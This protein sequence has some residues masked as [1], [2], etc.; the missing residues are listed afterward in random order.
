MYIKRKKI[1]SFIVKGVV[2]IEEF[3][4]KIHQNP[5]LSG[6]EYE[7]NLFVTK[8]LLKYDVQ[9]YNN[10]LSIVC[11]FN[12][13]KKQTVAFRSELDALPIKENVNHL[14]KSLN[15]N[16]HAC[17]HDVH[18]SALLSL[19]KYVS[20]NDFE[21]NIAFIFQSKEEGGLGAKE[22]IETSIFDELNITK[23]IGMHVWPNLEFDQL[24]SSENLMFGS[25]ELDVLIKGEN[26]H[27]SC[28]NKMTDATYASYKLY[29]KLYKNNKK[30]IYHLGDIKSG[31]L[32]NISSDKA[33]M[34][35]SLR[36]YNDCG[37]KET[38]LKKK[39]NTKCNI[40]YDFKGYFP[41]LKNDLSLLKLI[42]Y[43]EIKTLKSA[44]D[45]G[46]YRE[47]CE[48]LY[49]LYGLGKGFSL[50][51]SDFNTTEDIRVKYREKLLML[52][53]IFK[54]KAN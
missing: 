46:Y 6:L 14:I 1:I 40:T 17:G 31:N 12:K 50:H 13:N 52:I 47:K 48:T 19:A 42:D 18:T 24:F 21:Y 22:L 49:L 4:K 9:I 39:I 45:F 27:I 7:T 2:I 23:V 53:N 51:T 44:E 35:Y 41:P 32:R 8:E 36:F 43:K 29:K 25:Y 26:N 15:D 30:F 33:V 38:I 34:K 20:L 28:Y 3:Y 37:I 5:E 11:L 54:E 16:M 10:N